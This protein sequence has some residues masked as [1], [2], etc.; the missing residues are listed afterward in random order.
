MILADNHIK[1]RPQLLRAMTSLTQDECDQVLLH[2]PHA[3][4]QFVRQKYGDRANRQRQYGGG[5]SE[6]PVVPLE[7]K[8]LFSLY[9]MKVYP[10]QEVLAFEFGRV[11]R[12][13]HAWIHLLSAVWTQALDQGGSGPKRDAKQRGTMLVA[14][15][16]SPSG[17]DGPAR[18]RHRPHDPAKQKDY[19]RGKQKR[20][21]SSISLVV[22]S[23][24]APSLIG[25]QLLRGNVMRKRSLL[26]K[27]PHFPTTALCIKTPA[28]KAMHRRVS[29]RSNPR[30]N[31][32]DQR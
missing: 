23:L 5:R 14:E 18:L 4:N 28:V 8:L 3:W 7:E 2:F 24:R 27:T 9:Y 32:E 10:R 30:R 25:V 22:D 20:S 29:S 15:A 12:T 16:A 13:A 21:Q 19:D 1:A 6:E 17:R 26:Q 11:P 31:R